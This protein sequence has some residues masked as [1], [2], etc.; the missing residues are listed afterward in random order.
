MSEASSNSFSVG[1]AG[2]ASDIIRKANYGSHCGRA[3]RFE[4]D[5]DNGKVEGDR[6]QVAGFKHN[7]G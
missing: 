5:K 3:Y 7:L 4:Q 1:R 6:W 2:Q